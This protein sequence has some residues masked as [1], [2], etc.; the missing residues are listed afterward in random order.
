MCVCVCVC[1]R[2]RLCVYVY[3]CV[4]ACLCVCVR[5]CVRASAT[6]S[7]VLLIQSHLAARLPRLFQAFPPFLLRW[8]KFLPLFYLVGARGRSTFVRNPVGRVWE[9]APGSKDKSADYSRMIRLRLCL[10]LLKA[11]LLSCW[12]PFCISNPTHTLTGIHVP[13]RLMYLSLPRV[14]ITFSKSNAIKHIDF[15]GVIE[16]MYRSR[17]FGVFHARVWR[18]YF[19]VFVGLSVHFCTQ[20]LRVVSDCSSTG[21]LQEQC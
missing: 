12:V 13:F 19:Q 2:V 7:A 10:G 11:S 14:F 21:R 4:R 16:M 5:V 9:P 20:I 8:N 1:A 17:S 3:V 15:P 6:C 18:M